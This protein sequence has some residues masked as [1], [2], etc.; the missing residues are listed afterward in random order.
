MTVDFFKAT[1]D[2]I[3]NLNQTEQKLFDYVV[4]NMDEVKYMSIQKFA[5]Q[6][7]L[8]TTTI[9]RFTQ[10]LGFSGYTDFINS[11]LVTSHS[12]QDTALPDIVLGQGYSEEYL[13][14]A[15]EA[16][17]VMS[18]KQVAE[19]VG[20][21]NRK[22][23]IYV[24]TDDNT[25]AIG[26]YCE[27]LFIGLGFHAY[28][29]EAAYQTQNLV[30]RIG[31]DDMIIALSYSGQD[32]VLIDFIERVFLTERPYLL[33]VT[34]ADNNPLEGLSDANFYVFADEI[35]VPGMNLTSSVT[36]LMVIELLIYEYIAGLQSDET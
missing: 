30:N 33:S 31:A 14:N 24:L 29:P 21:L 3:R 5:S 12:Q 20:L 34:R 1:Q 18:P 10:K 22:P 36:M 17:R 9:F 35:H 19:V 11:L 13:K 4:K 7:F 8:S 26:Q 2:T 23:N 25:H 27:R 15:M 16:V 28:F 6:Q 32:V